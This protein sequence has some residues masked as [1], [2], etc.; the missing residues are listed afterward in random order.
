MQWPRTEFVGHTEGILGLEAK[1][2]DIKLTK[3][4]DF[5]QFIRSEFLPAGCGETI[6]SQLAVLKREN[7][8][9]NMSNSFNN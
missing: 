9:W 3:W 2:P 6:R 7:T 5:V 8:S 4:S 1:F